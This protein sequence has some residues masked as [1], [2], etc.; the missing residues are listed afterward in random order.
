MKV[1]AQEHT[2]ELLGEEFGVEPGPLVQRALGS[3]L[4]GTGEDP[5]KTGSSVTSPCF[6]VAWRELT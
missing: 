1:L 6:T 5:R 3:S 4:Y 2:V